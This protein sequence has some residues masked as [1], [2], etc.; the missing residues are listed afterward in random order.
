VVSEEIHRHVAD[1]FITARQAPQFVKGFDQ[2]LIFHRITGTS[3]LG[4][5]RRLDRGWMVGRSEELT[6]LQTIWQE[7]LAGTGTKPRAVVLRGDSGIG[8][9]RLAAAFTAD[10]IARGASALQVNGSPFHVEVGL[11][12]LR[13]FIEDRCSMRNAFDPADRLLRL[14]A[15]L[16]GLGLD[17]EE[18]LAL[19][20]PAVGIGPE[21]GYQ[22]A[23]SDARKLQQDIAAAAEAYLVACLGAGG[24]VLLLEDTQWFDD[25]TFTIVS[26]LLRSGPGNV[27]VLATS[28]PE[29]SLFSGAEVMDLPPLSPSECDTI[30]EQLSEEKLTETQRNELVARSDGVPLY[31]EE[32]VASLGHLPALGQSDVPMG[33]GDVPDNL[34]D[35]LMARLHGAEHDTQVATAAAAIGRTVDR[36]LL[37]AVTDLDGAELDAALNS[38]V[39]NRV[40]DPVDEDRAVL[41]FRHELLRE[42]AY[43]VMPPQRRH[44]I[45]GRVGDAL[46]T[47]GSANGATDWPVVA[48]HFE[49]AGRFEAAVRAGRDAAEAA[50]QRGELL[51]ARAQLGRSIAL[52][53][54][55]LPDPRHINLEIDLRL[56]HGYLA[57]ATDGNASP[58]AARDYER[59]LELVTAPGSREDSFRTLIVLWGYYTVRAELQRARVLLETLRGLLHDGREY[60]TPYNLAGF[61]MLDWYAGRFDSALQT[62]E[63]ALAQSRAQTTSHEEELRGTWFMPND[64]RAAINTHLAMT[65]MVTGDPAGAEEQFR[66]A[67]VQANALEFPAGPF[68]LA[69]SMAYEV[70]VCIEQC[71]LDDALAV[72]QRL[73]E[74]STERGLDSWLM[75]AFA[76]QATINALAALEDPSA[77]SELLAVHASII[78]GINDAWRAADTLAFLPF[79]LTVAGKLAAAAGDQ[80]RAR[81]RLGE[82]LE[83][84]SR[85]GLAF[86]DAETLRVQ[87]LLA[88]DPAAVDAELDRAL[89]LAREQ[90][91]RAFELRIALDRF[92]RGGGGGRTDLEAAVATFAPKTSYR[93][94]DEART[95]LNSTQ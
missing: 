51:E 57:T 28:R 49:L 1:L 75:V 38:L 45:H 10:A 19:L 24:S 64:P 41:R 35:L 29:G 67:E 9:S 61:G 7:V 83:L 44:Q 46:V 71:R 53:V 91:A 95:L 68:S 27:L 26:S 70:W 63:D 79:Y 40:F 62:L 76:E 5:R 77:G 39:A 12:P 89:A 34:Y 14:T 66:R 92:G 80:E 55:H 65:R 86:Y 11:H 21:A 50:R 47:A 43:E 94:L 60:F 72:V 25:S 56:R 2:P 87:A 13:A 74:L 48:T 18:T 3:P 6:R 22:P 58:D 85:T 82:A 88:E 23:A 36:D 16:K 81:E 93:E 52:V 37:T 32:L 31:L 4:I 73:I 8:K 17:A 84:S 20:A 59:C 30:V 69:Y 78:D 54:E 15:D 90:G 33:P 42:V